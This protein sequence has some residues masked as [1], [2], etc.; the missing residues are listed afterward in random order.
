MSNETL[1]TETAQTPTD[2]AASQPAAPAP[3]TA[4]VQDGQQQQPAA[5]VAKAPAEGDAKQG[6]GK[7]EAKAEGAPEAYEFAIPE[8]ANMDESGIKAFSE[9]AREAN[10]TQEVAQALMDKLAPAMAQRQAEAVEKIRS[11]WTES[12]KADTEF[13][14]DKLAE[15]MSVAKRALDAF[16]SDAL[17]QL[18]NETGLGNHPEIIRAFYRA[19]KAI[20]E[21]K[22]VVGGGG[23]AGPQ[24]LAERL[25]PS[26]K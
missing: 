6:E 18:L 13:G 8:G 5:E 4:A 14:G 12:A 3:A 21:D 10:L 19:G 15:N 1:M 9:F 20:S 16:G 22:V 17:R 11:E 23:V 25:Y 24:T 2:G 26:Q 7:P